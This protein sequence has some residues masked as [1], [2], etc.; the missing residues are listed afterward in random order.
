MQNYVLKQIS[1]VNEGKIEERDIYLKNG[2]I[3]RIGNALNVKER[4]TEI[5]GEKKHL[6]PG[7]IDDQVHF[8]EPGLTHKATIYT[9]SKAAIAGGVTSFME[10]PN[11]I[12]NALTEKLL[13]EKYSIASKSS[14]ANYS[15]YM[16]VSNDNADEVLKMN[17]RKKEVCGIKIFMGSS[18]GNM[19][20]DNEHALN[21]IFKESELLIAT[22]CEDEKIIK[23]N[24]NKVKN[25]KQELSPSDHP[26]IRD[27][28]ACFKS[29][30]LAVLLAEKY[31]SRLHVLHISTEKE[32]ELFANKIPL[33]QKKITAEVC[34]HHLHF[35]AED[36]E[37]LGY[38]IKCNP[39]IKD[40]KNKPALWNALLDDRLDVIATDHAP[41]TL[42]EKQGPYEHAHS[43]LPLVQHSL[44]LMLAYFKEG[45]ISL[46][47][48]VQKMSH[49][50]AACFKIE[51]RGYIREGYFADIVV[52][53][54]NEKNTVNKNNILYK[55]GWSP[56]EGYTFPA[57]ISST[58]V[59]GNC[60]YANDKDYGN[61]LWNE[62]VKGHRIL[63]SL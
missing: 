27:E 3:E 58:F 29:S 40:S 60:V 45:K 24:Y 56:M 10:M 13:E 53:D 42:E 47:K 35:T 59:N 30:S 14:L 61:T 28:N 23:E 55:C 16:G 31:D 43:G 6:F 21:R 4:V 25:A 38:L 8:R 49:S 20:V 39:A 18:T 34:V 11:T 33:A 15:F 9:E 2:R 57:A 41:H 54:L 48:I 50:V 7:V 5:D 22:H 19:L 17:A 52:V 63:F 51:N 46:E 26:Y 62:S 37:K 12:P 44:S 1:I 32:L 36:Y